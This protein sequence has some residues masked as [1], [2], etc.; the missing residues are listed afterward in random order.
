MMHVFTFALASI[1]GNRF[2]N[3][4]LSHNESD[5]TSQLLISVWFFVYVFVLCQMFVY[6]GPFVSNGPFFEGNKIFFLS[7]FL[8][9][10][11]KKV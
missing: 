1:I 5:Q 2:L 6:L 3:Q 4:A 11:G 7:E 9:C 8:N 10:M